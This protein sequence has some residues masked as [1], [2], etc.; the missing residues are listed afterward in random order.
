MTVVEGIESRG[1]PNLID[2]PWMTQVLEQA[3]VASGAVVESVIFDNLIGTGQMARNARLRLNWSEPEGRPETV[4]AKL[5]SDDATARATGYDNGSYETEWAFYSRMASTLTVRTPVCHAAL[6]DHGKPDFVLVMEDL[7][8]SAQGDQLAGLSADQCALALTQAV[9]IHAPR[10][11][12]T[13]LSEF[14]PHKAAPESAPE[15]LTPIYLWAVEQF[16]N[17]LGDRLDNDVVQLVNDLAPRMSNWITSNPLESTLIHL[18]FRADNL[19]FG[20]NNQAPPVAV[21][22]W[23][24]ASV[25]SAMWDVAYLLGAG[26][27]P[28]ER[29]RV[30]RD[31]FTDYLDQMSSAGVKLKFDDAWLA[32]R[33]GAIWGVVMAV[34]ATPL[35]AE[36]ERGNDMLTQMAQGHGRHAIDLESISLLC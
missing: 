28:D 35:A 30:E 12:D 34:I 20:S 11:G 17:R 14:S 24:T 7:C 8:H 22:D 1:D 10:W 19:L 9:G 25:G 29:A 18:D 3:G 13:T 23:Q 36:T 4:V 6:F 15:E 33:L 26:L 21:V 16:L 27:S 32:Y 2:G 5:P 31:L